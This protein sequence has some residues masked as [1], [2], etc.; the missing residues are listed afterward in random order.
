MMIWKCITLL[1]NGDGVLKL[2]HSE[3]ECTLYINA[4]IEFFNLKG[5]VDSKKFLR[6]GVEFHDKCCISKPPRLS[7]LITYEI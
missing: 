3:A 7:E 5:L 2:F 4:L 1:A 6:Y